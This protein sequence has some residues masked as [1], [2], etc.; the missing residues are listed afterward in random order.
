MFFEAKDCDWMPGKLYMF[1]HTDGNGQLIGQTAYPLRSQ[2][3]GPCICRF[4][5]IDSYLKPIPI[6]EHQFYSM[7]QKQ[8]A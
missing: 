2:T 1:T 6:N 3:I 4:E 5:W 7:A 8:A